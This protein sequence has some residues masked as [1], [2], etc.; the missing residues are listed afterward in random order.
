MDLAE[1]TRSLSPTLHLTVLAAL[2][3]AH[4]PLSGRGVTRLLRGKASQRGVA[5][6]L[7]YL[8]A[9]GLVLR[10]DHP[11]SASFSLNREHVAAGAAEA[12][13]E[14]KDTLRRRCAAEVAAWARRPVWAALFGSVVRGEG[15]AASDIDIA[16]IAA[17]E[18]H[19]DDPD[20]QAQ[21]DGLAR[22]IRL[23]TGNDASIITFTRAEFTASK[24]PV[25]AEIY[26][27]G[28]TVFG[29]RPGR[30]A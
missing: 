20:W 22:L 8:V 16:L 9:E 7:K 3:R 2:A 15:G 4:Q 25:V 6:A 24:E 26:R 13:G 10:E 29:R 5:D 12:L 14:L 28:V 1:P 21:V 30:K 18:H 19:L 23:W 11:P 27:D 17:D